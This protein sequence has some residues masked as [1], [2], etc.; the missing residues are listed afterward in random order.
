[1]KEWMSRNRWIGAVEAKR[2]L[3]N[4]TELIASNSLRTSLLK[5][6]EE[7]CADEAHEKKIVKVA[8][9]ECSV[10]TIVGKAEELSCVWLHPRRLA[11]H[12]TKRAGHEHRGRRASALCRE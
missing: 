4:D 3:L 12:P 8:G 7:T 10:L 11:V 9:L 6:A 5:R 2:L 1:M